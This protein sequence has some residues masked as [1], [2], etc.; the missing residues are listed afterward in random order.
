[1]STEPRVVRQLVWPAS[2]VPAASDIAL[3]SATALRLA[4]I[5][6]GDRELTVRVVGEEESRELNRRWRGKD[7]PTNV[8]AFPGPP[9]EGLESGADFPLGD[10][11]ISAPVVEREAASQ[12]KTLRQHWCHLI[13]HGT[14]HLAG[15]DHETADEALR[16]ERLETAVLAELGFPDPYEYH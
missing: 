2:G 6:A 5:E 7:S 14:L 9:G 15:F 12:R 8:L 16:M 13:V 10:L 4:G 3:W 1:M 11:V